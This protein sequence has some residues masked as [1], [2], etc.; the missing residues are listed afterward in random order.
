MPQE[1][2]ALTWAALLA[3]CTDFARSAVALPQKGEAGRLKNAVAPIIGLQAVTFALGESDRLP[4]DER[5][6]GLDRAE[7][8]IKQYAGE[9]HAIWRGAELHPEVRLLIDDARAA[10]EAA[11]EGGIE[12]V[13]AGEPLIADHPATL[14]E[15]LLALGFQG[16][17][18]VPSPGIPIL[19]DCPCVFVAAIGGGALAEPWLEAIESTCAGLG[20]RARVRGPRQAYRQLDFA[21]GKVTRDYIVPLTAP[22]PGGQPLLVWAIKDGAAQSVALAPRRPPDVP[23]VQVEFASDE[24]D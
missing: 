4:G 15:H 22:L 9:I 20:D 18:L 14:V 5:A 3:R 12:W 21:T 1:P 24:E 6:L 16:S 2:D 23:D 11:R 19:P 13:V 17:L 10:L 8:L 7:V